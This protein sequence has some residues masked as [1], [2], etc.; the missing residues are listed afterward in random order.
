LRL[1]PAYVT[2]PGGG[3]GMPVAFFFCSA[4]TH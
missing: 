4:F 3:I 1:L 2:V